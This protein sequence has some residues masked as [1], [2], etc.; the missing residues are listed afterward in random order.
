MRYSDHLYCCMFI[1]FWLV[2]SLF[3]HVLNCQCLESDCEGLGVPF[4]V[5]LIYFY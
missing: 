5:F 3:G 1:L 4:I 2:F